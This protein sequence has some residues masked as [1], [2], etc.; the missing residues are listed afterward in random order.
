MSELIKV[1]NL[2]KSYMSPVKWIVTSIFQVIYDRDFS[3]YVPT[4]VILLLLSLMTLLL[5]EKFY[6]TEDY[7]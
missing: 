6:N 5:C 1:K 4:M 3:Y 7:I 2:E